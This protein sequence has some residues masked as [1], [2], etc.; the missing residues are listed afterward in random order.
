MDNPAGCPR[1]QPQAVGCPQASQGS[2]TIY[3]KGKNKTARP[4]KP[5]THHE[6]EQARNA[7]V[8]TDQNHPITTIFLAQPSF[9]SKSVTF[10]ESPVTFAEI[11][12]IL[13]M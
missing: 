7:G 10:P 3:K 13:S 9:R 11:R 12:K 5:L 8:P 6:P 2:I 4:S 1:A